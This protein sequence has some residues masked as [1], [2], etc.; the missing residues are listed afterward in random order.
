MKKNRCPFKFISAVAALFLF[1]VFFSAPGFTFVID[2]VPD[3]APDAVSS[4]SPIFHDS[5]LRGI[6]LISNDQYEEALV[7]LDTL[8][9][10]YPDH[11]APYFFKAAT[12]QD[13]MSS[14]RTTR[15]Q[16][17]VDENVQL[18]IEK[19]NEL[20]KRKND[21][22]VHFYIGAAY[23]YRAFNRFRKHNWIGAYMDGRRGINQLKK[24]MAEDPS[25]YDVYL[26][27]GSY[28]Y[29]RTA[30]SKFISAAAFWM[31]DKREVG[32][33]QL[34]FAMQHG[35]YIQEKNTPSICDLYYKARLLIEFERWPEV[36][37]VFGE[38]LKKL[39]GDK[40]A[41]IGYL[42][43]C[44]YWIAVALRAQNKGSEALEWTQKATAQ[45][46]KRNADLELESP[47][48]DYREIENRLK[49]LHG[50]LKIAQDSRDKALLLA[51][52]PDVDKKIEKSEG[53]L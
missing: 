52:A 25:L 3:V 2:D 15:F 29:W 26:G 47:F 34:E 44:K 19:G 24:A 37:A 48:E 18:A 1:F 43:E 32:L 49:N 12:Y 35:L 27:L 17:Q 11:P 20:L 51:G 45:S 9:R 41:S 8:Q 30:K 6:E 14:F 33:R 40:F 46:E 36:E 4:P 38:I 13:W 31:K 7:L 5:L 23:G 16:K 22:W 53:E 28:H 42:V 10:M 39:E 50:A 21:A